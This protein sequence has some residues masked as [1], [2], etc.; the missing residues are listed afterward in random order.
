MHTGAAGCRGIQFYST[1]GA[2]QFDLHVHDNVIRN[3]ICDGLNFATVDPGKGVVEAYNNVVYHAG[4][5]PDPQGQAAGYACVQLR[6]SGS[7]TVAARVYNNTF[8]DCG[9]RVDSDSGGIAGDI[10]IE[11][12]NNVVVSAKAGE[13]YFTQA[14]GCGTAAGAKNDWFGAGAPPCASKITASISVDPQ[15]VSTGAT[16]DLHLSAQSPAV[17]AGDGAKA[18]AAD[19]DG[20]R[21]KSPPSLGAYEP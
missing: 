13:P 2:D 6:S 19:I 21:R 11:V 14:L 18:P 10:P 7:P 12:D 9:S 3:T 4:T 17:G 1:G 20:K 15:F 16:V 5:G 8:Y